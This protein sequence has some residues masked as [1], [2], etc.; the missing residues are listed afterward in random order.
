MSEAEAE[1]TVTLPSTCDMPETPR[2]FDCLQTCWNSSR[3][4]S[5]GEGRKEAHAY[6]VLVYLRT[7]CHPSL[8]TTLYLAH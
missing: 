4:S 6:Q 3:S 5:G 7:E 8:V 2:Y 1:T